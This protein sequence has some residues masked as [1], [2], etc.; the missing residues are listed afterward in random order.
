M[1]VDS[2]L[3]DAALV[4]IL[5]G[6]ATLMAM[7]PD[8]IFFDEAAQGAQRFIIVSLLEEHD[9]GVFGGRAFED[10]LYLVKAVALGSSGANVAAAAARI[11]VLLEDQ[12]IGTGSPPSV[13][14]YTWMDTF[15]EARV[16]LTEVDE[17]DPSIRWQH[18]G[19]HYR[20]RM[21]VGS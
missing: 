2:A 18:R 19:G 12:K 9:E 7:V 1:S 10:A 15:R 21:S 8:G 20:I 17:I 6:D 11:D 5:M 13:S 3:I 16:R 14:G 4:T